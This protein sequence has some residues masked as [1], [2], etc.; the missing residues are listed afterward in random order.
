MTMVYTNLMFTSCIKHKNTAKEIII[1]T[2]RVYS[3]L[4]KLE[5]K[6]SIIFLL[7]PYTRARLGTLTSLLIY[8]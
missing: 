2:H 4:V 3:W 5:K 1:Y 7:S 6:Q 8:V